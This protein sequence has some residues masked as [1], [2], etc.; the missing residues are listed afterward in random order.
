[1]TDEDDDGEDEDGDED[2]D[3][4]EEKKKKTLLGGRHSF[5]ILLVA[6]RKNSYGMKVGSFMFTSK[7]RDIY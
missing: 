1:M 5:T 4:D 7:K 2:E 3:E 6:G